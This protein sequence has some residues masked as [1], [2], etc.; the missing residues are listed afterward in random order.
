MHWIRYCISIV[1][2]LLV[3]MCMSSCVVPHMGEFRL[4]STLY[5]KLMFWYISVYAIRKTPVCLLHAS[6]HKYFAHMLISIFVASRLIRC[7]ERQCPTN[8]AATGAG[9]DSSRNPLGSSIIYSHGSNLVQHMI[10]R[11]GPCMIIGSELVCVKHW[12]SF[13]KSRL[14]QKDA[15]DA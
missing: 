15:A 9:S 8:N 14:L 3:C 13:D 2:P 11:H 12:G 6:I 7:V 10:P 1:L 5:N 4:Q